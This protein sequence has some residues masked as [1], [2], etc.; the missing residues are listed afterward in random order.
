MLAAARDA[1]YGWTAERLVRSQTRA[2]WRA[3]LYFFDHGYPSA[4]QAGLHAFHGAEI[5]YMF[6][7]LDRTPPRWPKAPDTPDEARLSAAMVG[8]WTSFARGGRP[9]AA[10]SPAW[11]AYGPGERYMAFR[12]EP[13][14]GS[15]LMPGLFDLHERAM[16][17][18]KEAGDLPWN[19]NVGLASPVLP[20]P[21]DACL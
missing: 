14:I 3:F 6:G 4:D 11:P 9:E 5:P 2:G 19:W 13:T 12:G 16:C 15:N 7:L 18:R 10:G 8:Y 21:S 1:T 20:G 17:R